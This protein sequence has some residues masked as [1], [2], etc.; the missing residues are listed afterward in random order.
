MSRPRSDYFTFSPYSLSQKESGRDEGVTQPTGPG[1]IW[2]ADC[3]EKAGQRGLDP[4]FHSHT[5]RESPSGGFSIHLFPSLV[6][7]KQT[8]TT[9]EK[10]FAIE[11]RALCSPKRREKT[12]FPP[13]SPSSQHEL[14]HP[15]NLGLSSSFFPSLHSLTIF[16]SSSR[17]PP[18]PPTS[19]EVPHTL[20]FILSTPLQPAPK[21]PTTQPIKISV[22]HNPINPTH[23]FKSGRGGPGTYLVSR[24]KCLLLP[25]AY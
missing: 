25:G 23:P 2:V 19:P 17:F 1:Q 3:L 8:E 13:C 16:P 7:L 21:T 15:Q 5:F 20:S 22:A 6:I 24:N 9:Q 4:D 18:P 11:F 14:S 12:I 10:Q